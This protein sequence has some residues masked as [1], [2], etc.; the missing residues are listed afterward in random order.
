MIRKKSKKEIELIRDAGALAAETLIRAGE[1]CKPG[2][3]TEE[4]DQFV[5]DYT[6]RHK[7]IPAPLNY[8]KFPKSC[9]TSVN[10][11]VCH[12][13]PSPQ[14]ILKEG[15]IINVD[16]TTILAGYHG[17]TNATFLVGCVA[18]DAE[19]LVKVA[20]ECL[21]AGIDAAAA[22]KARYSDI[23]A[24]IQDIADEHGYGVV[25]DYCGHGIGRAFHED[26]TVFHFRTRRPGPFIEEGHVFTIEPM[27]NLGNPETRVLKDNWTA[28]TQDGSLSAQWEHTVARTADGIDILTLPR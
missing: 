14:R 9:C 3:S 10:E 2:V 7:G 28:V 24:A 16:I 6:I 18:S 22:P 15:D 20:Y 5:Y 26:P 11:V 13:I 17:D 12:G 8:H 23:G 19:K 1:L 27:I 4:I 25:E 21:Q